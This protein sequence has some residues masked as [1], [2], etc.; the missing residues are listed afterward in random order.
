MWT[1]LLN[2]K[3]I[4][5]ILIA[6]AAGFCAGYGIRLLKKRKEK[7][8]QKSIEGYVKGISYI[9]D[10]ETDK[11]IEEL[12]KVAQTQSDLIDVYINIGS[13]F[14][15]RGEIN[16]A[17]IVHKSLLARP[18][19]S[20]EK[21]A[22][23]FI[24]LGI[25]YKKAGFYSRAEE[26]FKKALELNPRD[27]Q[28]HRFLEEVYEDNK[29]WESA[30]RW[31]KRFETKDNI[32]AHLYTEW[33]K[34]LFADGDLDKSQEK[35]KKAY[36]SDGECVDS[37]LWLGKTYK[38]KGRERKAHE[39]WKK[40]IV[41]KPSFSNLILENIEDKEEL[42]KMIKEMLIKNKNSIY[43]LYFAARSYERIGEL[44]KALGLYYFLFSKKEIKKMH[45]T[46]RLIKILSSLGRDNEGMKIM[47]ESLN[48]LSNKDIRYVCAQ[49]GFVSS[50]CFW[51]CPQCKSWDTVKVEI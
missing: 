22:D 34:K 30:T 28:A 40:T 23:I 17:L 24:N 38:A 36:D 16:R 46:Q 3:I 25:D 21:K 35:F 45:I 10:D 47:K 9:I 12:A 39:I 41:E 48:Y 37:C 26:T 5:D 7:A 14:R 19:L 2:Q 51:R 20:D 13:L 29:D 4:L 11:A 43:A 42:K 8:K 15:K 18:H 49:C 6:F 32:V 33:G 50:S 44:K 31:Q 1:E 27:K